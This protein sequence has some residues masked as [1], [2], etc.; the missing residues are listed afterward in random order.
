MAMITTTTNMAAEFMPLKRA[1]QRLRMSDSRLRW[2]CGHHQIGYKWGRDWYLT[3][4]N[5]AEIRRLRR[6]PGRPKK[7]EKDA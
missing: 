2:L 1:A 7:T 6:K 3:P 5:V 4:E